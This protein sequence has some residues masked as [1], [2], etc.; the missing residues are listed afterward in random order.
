[1]NW[2]IDPS[3]RIKMPPEATEKPVDALED[4]VSHH[5]S[6]EDIKRI[7]EL[8]MAVARK[9]QNSPKDLHK[10]RKL[11]EKFDDRL[12]NKTDTPADSETRSGGQ[13]ESA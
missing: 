4:L 11:L 2:I 3:K 13:L 5:P 6:A 10:F 12:T 7:S 1:M 9:C 8:L